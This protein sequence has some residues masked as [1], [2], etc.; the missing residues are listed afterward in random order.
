MGRIGTSTAAARG[1]KGKST[2][3]A[4][5][6]LLWERITPGPAPVRELRFHPTRQWRFDFAW[7]EHKLAVEI[8]G[9][10]FMQGGHNRGTQ[11]ADD[12]EKH[13]AAVLLGWRLLRYTTRDLE[14]RPVQV[15][16]EVAS[17]LASLQPS[18]EIV[19]QQLLQDPPNENTS[20]R[21]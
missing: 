16:Q 9:G 11:F 18:S 13:N 1:R 4:G 14:R 15:V 19:R 17:F 7:P 2:L 10:I 20:P 3:E 8:D 21:P 12:A 6:A 5:F